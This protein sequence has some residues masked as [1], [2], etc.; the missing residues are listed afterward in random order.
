MAAVPYGKRAEAA[1]N[2]LAKKLLAIMEEKQTNL[3]VAADLNTCAEVLALADLVGPYVCVLKTHV[4]VMADFT[5]QFGKDL[6]ALADK[7][8]FMIFEDRKFADIGNTVAMQYSGG[9]Y[10]I[11]S[12]SHIT[13][14]HSVPG[15]GI[16]D[17][18]ADVGLPLGRGLLM[19]GEMSSS[20]TLAAGAYTD[21]TVKMAMARK[22]FV[23]GFI[24]THRLCEDAGMI[25]MTPGVQLKEGT[26]NMGQR[27]LTPDVV[28]RQRESDIII[29][30]RGIYKAEDPSKA[31]AEYRDKGWAAYKDRLA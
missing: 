8:R 26:D 10:G 23:M 7:H 15:P 29:V 20:G 1:G 6:L 9:V 3:S 4:D 16:I 12:W 25:H 22:D 30:G 27:Y 5:P 18:L 2:E 19:L 17:G 24:C 14:A 31:A 11:A 21:A 13:N 28:I